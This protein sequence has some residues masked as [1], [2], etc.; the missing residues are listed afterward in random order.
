MFTVI[1]SPFCADDSE[2]YFVHCLK[3]PPIYGGGEYGLAVA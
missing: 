3:S 1:I 2:K